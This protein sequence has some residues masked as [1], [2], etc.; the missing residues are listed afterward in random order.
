LLMGVAWWV[1]TRR[2]PPAERERRRR[3]EVSRRGRMGEATVTEIRQDVVYYI[4][5]VRGVAYT[6]SQDVSSLLDRFPGDPAKVIGLAG[7]KYNPQ[8]PANSIIICEEWSGLR[9]HSMQL[10]NPREAR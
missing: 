2:Q 10:T 8:N 3:L 5:E 7:L 4:Y 9:A 6:T 1:L